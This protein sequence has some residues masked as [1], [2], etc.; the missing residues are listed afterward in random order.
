MPIEV[1]GPTGKVHQFD[2][3]T[4]QDQI[5]AQMSKLYGTSGSLQPHAPRPGDATPASGAVMPSMQSVPNYR[6]HEDDENLVLGSL[7]PHMVPLIQNTPGHVQR[8]EQAKTIGKDLGNLEE[9]QRAGT[10]VRDMLH[11]LGETA[12]E[13]HARGALD[14]AIGPVNQSDIFQRVRGAIPGLSRWYEGGYNLHNQLMHDIDGLV[15]A[16]VASSGNI[17]MSD[18]RQKAFTDTMGR[19]MNATNKTEFDKIK[20]DAERIINGTFG[21]APGAVPAGTGSGRVAVPAPAASTAPI[22]HN[23]ATGQRIQWDGTA[24]RQVN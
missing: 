16:F 21:L 7:F 3:T 24:W 19:M 8:V 1:E 5:M 22:Y 13:G 12:D 18:S 2:D 6:S 15:T 17:K 14:Q 9:K 20:K 23:P 11:Q 10:Q 4:P